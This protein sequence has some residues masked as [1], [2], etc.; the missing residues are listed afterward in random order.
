MDQCPVALVL[1]GA[2]ASPMWPPCYI[3]H[4][5]WALT[6]CP[7]LRLRAGEMDVRPPMPAAHTHLPPG[8]LCIYD[9]WTPSALT[10]PSILTGSPTSGP[11]SSKTT[12]THG[13]TTGPPSSTT[14]PPSTPTATPTTVSATS[15]GTS[16]PIGHS[17][18]MPPTPQTTSTLTSSVTAPTVI[19]L[20]SP[21]ITT[22]I[23]PVTTTP[24]EICCYL[25]DTYYAPG[26][27]AFHSD[28]GNAGWRD[29]A[30]PVPRG[31]LKV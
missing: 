8:R 24:Q 1:P 10:A 11:S 3:H 4:R 9:G 6:L 17:S 25:N 19:T 7:T 15:T 23:V 2:G 5:L 12:P 21:N 27:Q 14:G 26:T 22:S 16:T 13:A 30:F 20:T 28:S 18:T 29:F 31:Q